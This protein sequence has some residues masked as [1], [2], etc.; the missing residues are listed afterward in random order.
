VVWLYPYPAH[1]TE[2]VLYET[3]DFKGCLYAAAISRDGED[4]AGERAVHQVKEWI[5][6][7][8]YFQIDESSESYEL[9]HVITSDPAF[10]KMGYRHLNIY[11][12]IR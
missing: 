10:E 3:V 7:T 2:P 1:P 8:N 12:S 6:T 9:F 5:L 11:V 4:P